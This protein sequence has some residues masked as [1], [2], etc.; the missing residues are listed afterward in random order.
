MGEGFRKKIQTQAEAKRRGEILCRM[1]RDMVETGGYSFSRAIGMFD[2]GLRIELNG[3]RFE[4]PKAE[5]MFVP[6]QGEA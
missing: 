6:A 4:P 2:H 3:G 1:F 5:G